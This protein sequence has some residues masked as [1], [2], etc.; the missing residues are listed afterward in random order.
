MVMIMIMIMVVPGTRSK[1][2]RV[3]ELGGNEL[4]YGLGWV[5]S[6]AGGGLGTLNSLARAALER[7]G[8]VHVHKNRW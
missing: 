7:F 3:G 1:S 5:V 2:V 6:F 8:L 4:G